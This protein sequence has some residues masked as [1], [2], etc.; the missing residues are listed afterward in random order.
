M[1]RLPSSEGMVMLAIFQP[2]IKPMP[3]LQALYQTALSIAY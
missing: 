1:F 3:L 2:Q